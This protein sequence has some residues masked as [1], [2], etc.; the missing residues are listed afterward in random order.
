MAGVKVYRYG[1]LAPVEQSERVR[2][3]MRL[4]HRYRNVLVE[5]ERARRAALRTLLAGHGD[6]AKLTVVAQEADAEIERLY[7]SAKVERQGART[8]AISDGVREA[9]KAAKE[10][11]KG[12]LAAAREARAA[13]KLD[14]QVIEGRKLIE[15]RA[16]YL[17]RN[18]RAHCAVYWGSYLGIEAASEQ[19][20][21]M[22]LYD[23]VEPNDPRFV[24]WEG[25]GSVGVQIQKGMSSQEVMGCADTRLRI[26]CGVVPKGVDP[27]SKRAAKRQHMVLAI[28]VGSEGR[29]P[30]WARFPMMMHRPLPADGI[31]KWASVHLRKRGPREEWCVTITVETAEARRPAESGAVAVD[32][33]W[34]KFEDG[35]LRVATWRGDDGKGGFL[36][37]SPWDLSRIEKANDL[38]SIRD[39]NFDKAR[40]A[41]VDWKKTA[42]VPAWFEKATATL[43]QWRAVA[44]LVALARRWKSERFEGDEAGYDALETWR[45]HDHHIWEWESS[46]RIKALRNRREI[47]R[48]F[49]A[50]LAKEYRTVVLE[51]F[52][53]RK[54]AERPA[55][56]GD[57]TQN[58]T[59]RTMRHSAAVSELRMCITLAFVDRVEKVPAENTTKVCNPCGSIQ[60]WDQAADLIHTCTECGVTWDQDENAA[61][62]LLALRTSPTTEPAVARESKWSKTKRVAAEKRQATAASA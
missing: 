9:L 45:Y 62:N 30:I 55:V 20:A 12:A 36:V 11:K 44:R 61:L 26:E 39:Q 46:Q 59:A 57:T 7:K 21:K 10:T 34:R 33:G 53:L 17:R 35:S 52:D 42:T 37:L 1:L 31:I 29:S 14:E 50:K 13:I 38:R 2:S 49:A 56:D 27:T 22:P 25:E 5:I 15:E 43:P 54:I 32:L 58:P 24:R 60:V 19:M 40:I 48:V 8:R 28:R 41:L 16:A 4:A 23:G 6:V 18:A 47:Y 3:Q 51:E